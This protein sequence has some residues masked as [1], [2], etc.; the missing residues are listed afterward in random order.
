MFDP[1][2]AVHWEYNSVLPIKI[3]SSRLI[4]ILLPNFNLR[5]V[6]S[7]NKILLNFEFI[8]HCFITGFQCSKLF[9]I[10]GFQNVG[11]TWLIEEGTCFWQV[12]APENVRCFYV[13]WDIVP[14]VRIIK[15]IIATDVLIHSRIISCFLSIKERSKNYIK[16]LLK[17]FI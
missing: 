12:Y 7:W 17:S 14:N 5:A 8:K 16:I 13:V 11:V 9:P 1:I 15:P 10:E 2:V 6:N 4:N 3:N